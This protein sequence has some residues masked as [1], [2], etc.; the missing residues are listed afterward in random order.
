MKYICEDCFKTLG[1]EQK[2]GKTWEWVAHCYLCQQEKTKV[3]QAGN[4]KPKKAE[5]K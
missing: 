1:L 5:G 3:I 2:E 4:I